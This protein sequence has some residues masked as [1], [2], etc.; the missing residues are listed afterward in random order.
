M[1]GN[2]SAAK[3]STDEA[4]KMIRGEAGTSIAVTF[5]RK[6]VKE[7]MVKTLVRA[8][9]EIPTI[10]TKLLPENVF[11]IELYSFSANSPN[12]FRKALRKFVESGSDKLVLD[13]R[14]NPGGYLEAAL[15][16]SS[17]FL[18]TGE[19][20]VIEDFG[21][22]KEPEI[23]RSKGYDI[24]TGK[25]K[26]VILV[27]EGSASA[28]EILAGALR[29]YNKAIL[30]GSKTFGKGSVQELVPVTG[31]TSLKVTVAHW[32][33]PLGKSIS[34]GGLTPDIEVKIT[35]ENTKGGKDPQ[36]DAAVKYLTK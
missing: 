21:G 28:S 20:V 27:N 19:T 26:F 9:I 35:A 34:N 23:Y 32:L 5:G 8:N 31:D 12:L 15:D 30:I 25:L 2:V 7:P 17:W 1:I 3:M 16:M 22:K 33:T 6:G 4:I 13:L 18:P 29:E 11:V 36:M 24:F 14:N 10:N